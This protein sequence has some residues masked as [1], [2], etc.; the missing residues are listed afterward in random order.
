MSLAAQ[1]RRYIGEQRKSVARVVH[2]RHC[3]GWVAQATRLCGLATRRA[4]SGVAD[5][6][7][8]AAFLPKIAL[9]MPPGQWPGGTGES[10]VLPRR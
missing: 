4:E 8:E 2:T 7:R 6:S 5:C 1:R 10:P 3:L 9:E